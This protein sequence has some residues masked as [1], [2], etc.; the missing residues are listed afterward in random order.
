VGSSFVLLL[1]IALEPALA[2]VTTACEVFI[3]TQQLLLEDMDICVS[4]CVP[5]VVNGIGVTPG[6]SWILVSDGAFP[7][8][9]SG[10]QWSLILVNYFSPMESFT[11]DSSLCF[12]PIIAN[13][14][15]YFHIK[16]RRAWGERIAIFT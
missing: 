10:I 1:L 2:G 8:V 7:A 6:S 9:E 15:N 14:L 16:S 5:N 11:G 3:S 4:K 13:R 12:H